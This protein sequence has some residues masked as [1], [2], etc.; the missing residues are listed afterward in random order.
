MTS[1]FH[2]TCSGRGSGFVRGIGAGLVAYD[3]G[4]MHRQGLGD[5]GSRARHRIMLGSGRFGS[6]R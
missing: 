6:G 2:V 5:D 4:S 1:K 3:E